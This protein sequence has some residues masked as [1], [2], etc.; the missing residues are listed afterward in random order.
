MASRSR[1][2]SR[3]KWLPLSPPEE[4]ALAAADSSQL[5]QPWRE[6]A[7]LRSLREQLQLC[8]DSWNLLDAPGGTSTP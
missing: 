3:N 2:R 6:H 5:L 4:Q 8:F 1:T 7:T